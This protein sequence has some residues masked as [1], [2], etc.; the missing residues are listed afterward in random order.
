[1]TTD[2]VYMFVDRLKLESLK[3]GSTHLAKELDDALHMG[4]SGLEIMGAIRQAILDHHSLIQKLL[5]PDRLDE[6]NRV[7]AFVDKAYGRK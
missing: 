7:V 6:A 3:Q 2:D 4:S 1:M 5:G